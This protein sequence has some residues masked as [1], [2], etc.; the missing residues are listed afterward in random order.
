MAFT[1][2]VS[3]ANNHDLSLRYANGTPDSQTLTLDVDGTTATTVVLPPTGGWANWATASTVVTL[4]AGAHTLRYRFGSGDS[5]NV[6]LDEL[7]VT[8]TDAELG[9]GGG[10]GSGGDGSTDPGLT[11]LTTVQP[12]TG[13][14][15]EAEHGFHV[16]GAAPAGVDGSMGVGGLLTPGARLIVPVWSTSQG[17]QTV[18]LRVVNDSPIDQRIVLDANGVAL[19]Y[20]V[21]PPGE[22]WQ[23]IGVTVNL[24]TGLGSVGFRQDGASTGSGVL[25]VDNATLANGA[26]LAER[27]ASVPFTTYEAEDGGTNAERLGPNRTFRQVAAEASSREAVRLADQG[28][29]VEWVLTD[30]ADALVLRASIP[31]TADG[32]GQDATLGLYADGVK[33]GD[34]P[35]SS[36]YAWVYGNYPYENTPSLGGAQRFFDDSRARFSELTAGTVLRLAKDAS[37]SAARYD[38]DLVETE[39]VPDPLSAPAGYVDV[40]DHGALP[41]D[42]LDDRS[43][44][45]A[46]IS[47][48][49]SQDSGVWVPPGRF[50]LTARL[51][52]QDVAIR[53][54]GP[55]H[56]VVEG[57][58]GKGGFFATGSGV[59]IAD[60]MIDGD[61]RYR[62]DAA[63]D[64]ALEGNFGTGS[65]L[66]NI[67]VEHTKVG[68][69]A[70]SGTR[71]LLAVG[72]RIRN[73]FADGVNF[74]ADV[75]D[76]QVMQ[77]MLR[78]TGDDALAM[79]SDGQ[80]V[81]RSVFAFNTVHTPML[82]NGVGI[83]GGEANRAEDNVIRDTL[84]GSAGIAIGTRFNPVPLSGETIAQRN[85][86]V[87][88]GGL[89]PNWQA[90]FGAVWI[91]ADSA[92][93][94]SPVTIRDT[95]ILDSTYSGVLVSNDNQ[96][97]D[98]RLEDVVIDGTGAQ[99]LKV[100]ATGQATLTNVTM[101]DLGGAAIEAPG[102]FAI[103][104]GGGNN[105]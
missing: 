50:T 42:G 82:G 102:G 103:V 44:F 85:T 32:A 80:P 52:V 105:F 15:F 99:G 34:V 53:G 5:G 75:Q 31:D 33:I 73:T 43:A 90:E 17:D 63:F 11:D 100:Q 6:N 86:L 10:S 47:T 68:L 1:V 38:I 81:T 76:T 91:F 24:A 95:Q 57:R 14:R 20:L 71:G 45:S 84:T 101:R 89:E 60:L 41:D 92:P 22:G 104:D 74:H 88:T 23:S 26:P 78:N 67:W 40:R 79:W 98:L 46:A 96:V 19:G 72:L 2:D 70:D 77:S 66:Q 29:F 65:L 7:S 16:D 56:S 54:A 8:T 83:Y 58:N 36:R 9:D 49:R 12:T 55:W 94:T 35:V 62:D 87:R 93:I 18:S 48:A 69:W 51:D 97:S 30:P 4:D 61:V 21:I 64:A 27:G 13:T 28:E 37:S 59:V 25:A 3:A 39:V